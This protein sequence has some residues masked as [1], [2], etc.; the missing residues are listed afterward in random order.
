VDKE[1]R[2]LNA[3]R[4]KRLLPAGIVSL[5]LA[6]SFVVA[7]GLG[8]LA[9]CGS[10]TFT[11]TPPSPHIGGTVVLSATG[12]CGGYGGGGGYGYGANIPTFRFW[13]LD[14]GRYWSMVQDYSTTNSYNWNTTGLP[15]GDYRLEVDVKSSDE[16]NSIGYDFVKNM[17]YHIGTAP[18]TALLTVTGGTDA[19]HGGTGGTFTMTGSSTGCTTPTYKFWIQD[20][21]RA[22]SV[23]QNY[24]ATATH[25]WG[26]V[27]T[28]Y[29]GQYRMEVD[30]RDATNT[31]DAYEAVSNVTFNLIGCTAATL[32]A[33]PPT[34]VTGAAP[35]TL[36]ATATCQGTPTYRFWILDP[37]G[38]HWSIVK[39][40]SVS[41]T[42]TWAA[43]NQVKGLSHIEVDVRNQ[44][45]LESYEFATQGITYT[46]T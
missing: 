20:P 26:P 4:L 37:G 46:F 22:W 2:M 12:A 1:N 13:I 3:R 19:T 11:A 31:T 25:T 42:Y 6:A 27:G 38:A 44:G 10:G 9:S 21:G 28:Y 7:P 43:A 45:S 30:V 24:S 15:T 29:L 34:A 18:C 32:T 17:T 23:V 36:T 35:V 39:D 16:P 14:P 33:A 8:T 40:F 5:V 41:N